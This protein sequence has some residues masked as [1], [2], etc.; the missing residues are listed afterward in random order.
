[1][2]I[3]DGQ[4]SVVTLISIGTSLLALLYGIVGRLMLLC[5]YQK[6]RTVSYSGHAPPRLESAS[7]HATPEVQI[8]P[9]ANL[10]SSG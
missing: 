2:V 1:M 3:H 5:M 7:A 10:D 8:Y 9:L 6:H 4:P